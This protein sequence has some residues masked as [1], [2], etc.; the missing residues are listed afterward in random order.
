MDSKIYIFDMD[1]T[2]VDSHLRY[3]EGILQVLDE[4]GITYDADTLI[5]ILNPLGF[6][7]SAAYYS[8][9]G[10]PGTPEEIVERMLDSMQRLYVT[11][12]PLFNGVRSY[13]DKLQAQGARLFLLTATPHRVSDACLRANGIYDYFEQVWCTDDFGCTKGDT[14]LF[15]KIAEAIGCELREVLYF[16]DGVTAIRTARE[17]GMRTCGVL[18]PLAVENEGMEQAADSCIVSFEELV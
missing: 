7:K 8:R 9:L 4:E 11:K 10:V 14:A 2:L 12:V 17:A 16:D 1:D 6:P 15:L 13:L 18:S 5:P 3:T